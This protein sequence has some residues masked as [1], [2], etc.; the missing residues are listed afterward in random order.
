MN[1]SG[2]KAINVHKADELFQYEIRLVVGTRDPKKALE[3]LSRATGDESLCISAVGNFVYHCEEHVG[4]LWVSPQ[5]GSIQWHSVM[6]HEIVHA[7]DE[8]LFVHSVPPGREST[9]V[10]ALLTGLLTKR[11]LEAA[12]RHSGLR[13]PLHP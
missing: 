3:F 5:P 8:I 2:I 10:R 11:V 4:Y 6:A 12:R 9:E 13:R 1:L 7:V